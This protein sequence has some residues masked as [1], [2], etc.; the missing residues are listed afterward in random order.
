M[1]SKSKAEVMLTGFLDVLTRLYTMSSVKARHCLKISLPDFK[2]LRKSMNSSAARSLSTVECR[3]AEELGLWADCVSNEEASGKG[4]WTLLSS[5]LQKLWTSF[6]DFST[7][8]AKANALCRNP[9]TVFRFSNGLGKWNTNYFKICAVQL[10]SSQ[11]N[12]RAGLKKR[13]GG[14]VFGC[15]FFPAAGWHV[16]TGY[17]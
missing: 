9:T 8:R 17:N 5:K 4:G 10:R 13:K 7:L 6:P 14:G 11:E 2:G 1:K 15:H 3:L 16:P 12:W